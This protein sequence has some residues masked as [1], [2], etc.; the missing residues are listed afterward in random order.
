MNAAIDAP[1][2]LRA[3]PG[4][5]PQPAAAAKL[6]QREWLLTAFF[7][8]QV[9]SVTVLQ[10]FGLPVGGDV[11]ELAVFT[12]WVG[13]GVLALNGLV[14]L[15]LIRL[16]LFCVFTLVA[17]SSQML[18]AEPFSINSVFLALALYAPFILRF[19]VSAVFYRRC[20]MI[21]LNVILAIGALVVLQQLMQLS[22]GW[23]AWPDIDKLAPQK[24]L[25][26]GYNYLQPVAYGSR[27]EKPNAFLF[28]EDSFV[29]QFTA[30]ALLIELVL[31]QRMVRLAFYALVLMISFAGTGLLLLALCA[32]FI[33]ARLSPRLLLAIILITAV[34]AIAAGAVGWY[35]QVAQRF[36]EVGIQGS[37]GY[38]RFNVPFQ[39]VGQMAGDPKYMFTG[40]GAGSTGA[41]QGQAVAGFILVPFAKIIYEYG[42]LTFFAFYAFFTWSLFASSSN[43]LLAWALFVFFNLGGGG[44]VVPVYVITCQA[45]GTLLRIEQPDAAW[46]VMT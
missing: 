18:G 10:K 29:S 24:L 13:V 8:V 15:D 31:F 17:V 22:V 28:L 37:S 14:A 7:A 25:F 33:L 26:S 40:H 43:R 11:V 39:V 9:I 30:I 27:F 38:Y 2:V 12:T 4:T 46:Q 36:G 41:G 20:M 45:L 23:R 5:I 44:F 16:L 21:F 1:D 35:G 19:N 6:G 42:F 34:G 3:S 32:P